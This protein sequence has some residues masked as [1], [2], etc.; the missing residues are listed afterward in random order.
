MRQHGMADDSIVK[1]THTHM[2][3]KTLR[4]MLIG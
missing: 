4:D 2:Q 3:S 1:T